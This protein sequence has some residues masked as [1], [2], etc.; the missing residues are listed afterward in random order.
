MVAK[1]VHYTGNVQ[2]VGFRATASSIARRYPLTGYVRNLPDGRVELL[3]EGSA[4]IVEAF[5]LDIRDRYTGDIED[6]HIGEL[7]PSGRFA[8]FA[9]AP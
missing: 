9:I 3:V 6:E 1:L 7:E 2:G 8:V 4:T 5:L